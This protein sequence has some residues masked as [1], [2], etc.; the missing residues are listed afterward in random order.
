[1]SNTEYILTGNT[2]KSKLKGLNNIIT[3]DQR[4]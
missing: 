1:V 2:V 3:K 4:M